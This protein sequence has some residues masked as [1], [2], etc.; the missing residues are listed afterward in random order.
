[1]SRFLT[2]IILHPLPLLSPSKNKFHHRPLFQNAH[3]YKYG[4]SNAEEERACR[5]KKEAGVL[6][7]MREEE[8][9]VL[10]PWEH[11]TGIVGRTAEVLS[12][13]PLP[14]TLMSS[15][16]GKGNN[17]GDGAERHVDLDVNL[18]TLVKKQSAELDEHGIGIEAGEGVG[19]SAGEGEA[20]LL[21]VQQ[22]LRMWRLRQLLKGWMRWYKFS[23]SSDS[24][25]P[26]GST[27]AWDALESSETVKQVISDA[28]Q[29]K[30]DLTVALDVIDK[31][32]QENSALSHQVKNLLLQTF[33][34]KTA[35]ITVVN[36]ASTQG[37]KKKKKN[38]V[39]TS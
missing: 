36:S 7:R 26:D 29:T 25:S 35:A 6:H 38:A 27:A 12:L 1:L 20:S 21:K 22:I 39:L 17:E 23:F 16:Y 2:P 19:G 3:T 18:F 14:R 11:D 4:K 5:I 37:K 10:L 33:G 13:P 31:L 32:Q 30:K 15:L 24:S 8:L 28:E 34:L 9:N